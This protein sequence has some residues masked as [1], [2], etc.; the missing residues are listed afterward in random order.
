MKYLII[1]FTLISFQMHAQDV[2][3]KKDGNKI[4]AKVIEITSSTIKYRNWDQPDGP[5][6]NI[7]ISQVKEIIYDNGTWETFDEP[8]EEDKTET[9]EEAPMR[10]TS[11]ESSKNQDPLFKNGIFI[12]GVIGV[13]IRNYSEYVYT[14]NIDPNTGFDNGGTSQYVRN[15]QMHAMLS[16]RLGSKW[17]F[18]QREMWKPGLQTTW[19]RFGTYIG[20][21]SFDDGPAIGILAGPKT[22]SVCN[23]G[24]ANIFKLSESIGVEANLT[25]GYNLELYPYDGIMTH[26]ISTTFEA[27]FRFNKLSIGLDYMHIFGLNQENLVL[28]NPSNG[29]RPAGFDCIGISI[30][31]KF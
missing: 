23:V 21:E 8:R 14:P 31:G 9:K 13:G 22:F 24:F 27:K 26:G 5:V 6:R 28:V 2:I 10:P 25:G 1:L 19:F 17:Y 29:F 4:D 20:G 16:V 11:K 3:M 7:E 30:G 12:D 15:S 18:G